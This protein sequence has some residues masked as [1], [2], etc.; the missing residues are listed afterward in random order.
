MTATD[1]TGERQNDDAGAPKRSDLVEITRIEQRWKTFGIWG[2]C[3]AIVIGIKI[4]ADA[5]VEIVSDPKW[6]QVVGAISLALVA[7]SGVL[8]L[9]LKSR[10]KYVRKTHR[11]TAELEQ[12]IDKERSS[13]SDDRE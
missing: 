13:S 9:L 7:P 3:V 8:A 11:R 10:V 4:I 12:V 2:I 6:W 5:V 1:S